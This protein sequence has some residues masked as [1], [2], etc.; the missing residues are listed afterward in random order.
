MTGAQLQALR[1]S[2]RLQLNELAGLL[3]LSTRSLA[4]YE[5]A[6]AV[7]GWLSASVCYHLGH[8]I[9]SVLEVRHSRKKVV[10]HNNDAPVVKKAGRSKLKAS[11]AKVLTPFGEA[12]S[13]PADYKGGQFDDL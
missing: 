5:Q 7:P 3:D 9:I 12:D 6:E 2:R 4:R 1:K 13:R 8:T 10:N 11:S